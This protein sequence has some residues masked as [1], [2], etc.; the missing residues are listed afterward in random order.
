M[1]KIKEVNHP[2]NK[3][4]NGYVI[5]SNNLL[6]GKNLYNFFFVIYFISHMH[7]LI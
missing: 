2:Q 4:K 6:M 1:H 3:I 5:P 7:A